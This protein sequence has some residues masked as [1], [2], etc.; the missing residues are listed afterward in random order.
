MCACLRGLRLIRSSENLPYSSHS[1]LDL[2]GRGE[3][4]RVGVEQWGLLGE[5]WG[6][7]TGSPLD[8][9]G[10]QGLGGSHEGLSS[11]GLVGPPL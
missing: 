9:E 11:G 1:R 2:E 7:W 4:T 3:E 8:E 6:S 10:C 5:E